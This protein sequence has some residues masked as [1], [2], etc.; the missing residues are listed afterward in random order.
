VSSARYYV[1]FQNALHGPYAISEMAD[2]LTEEM[3]VCREGETAWHA[4]SARDELT[5]CLA[6]AARSVV[7]RSPGI[8]Y[9]ASADGKEYGPYSLE[10]LKE[11]VKASTLVRVAADADWRPAAELAELEHFFS[12]MSSSG[13]I[14]E[15]MLKDWFLFDASDARQGPYTR[16][17]IDD[18][19]K[20]EVI[21]PEMK[22]QHL[23]WSEPRLL[24]ETHLVQNGV[25]RPNAVRRRT[26]YYVTAV[27][28]VLLLGA[29]AAFFRPALDS[30]AASPSSASAAPSPPAPIAAFFTAGNSLQGADQSTSVSGIDSGNSGSSDEFFAVSGLSID[31]V[32]GRLMVKVV[33]VGQGDGIIIRTP[34]N[35]F[36]LVDAGAHANAMLPWLEK[37]GVR[38]ITA[39]MLSHPHHDHYAGMPQVIARYPVKTFYDAGVPHTSAAY[40]RLLESLLDKNIDYVMPRAGDVYDWGDGVKAEILHP[41]SPVYRNI[42]DNSIVFRLTF[43]STSM[44]FTGDAEVAAQRA[45]LATRPEKLRADIYK[46]GHH[47]SHNATSADWL[48]AIRPALAVISCGLSNQY[49]H[50]HA[51]VMELLHGRNIRILRTDLMGSVTFVSDGVSWSSAVEATPYERVVRSTTG[52]P[53][54]REDFANAAILVDSDWQRLGPEDRFSP[55]DNALIITAQPGEELYSTRRTAS[56]LLR[57]APA[58]EKWM[59]SVGMKGSRDRG[60]DGALVLYDDE[61][62]WLALSATEAG[63]ISL[64]S[65]RRGRRSTENFQLKTPARYFALERY[66]DRLNIAASS[67]RREWFVLGRLPLQKI[68]FSLNRARIGFAA[69]AWEGNPAMASFTRFEEYSLPDISQ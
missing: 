16:R 38:E 63:G 32:P 42:N 34:G 55:G 54:L 26:W 3:M 1:S 69:N 56:M 53:T 11:F 7:D 40:R 30:A 24:K 52:A 31:T 62:H 36:Y 10:Q 64:I 33:D 58:G 47:G 60:T 67:D 46:V 23:T 51:V 68:G 14:E 8:A 48:A 2:F 39:M 41:D 61:R 21:S 44:L 17:E 57:R 6:A 50:P 29:G 25:A 27:L 28:A 19:V 65:C 66:G 12:V 20:R 18:L 35:R 15:S 5:P 45:V 59:V 37:L 43:G 22:I 9:F 49:G 4:A 13:E